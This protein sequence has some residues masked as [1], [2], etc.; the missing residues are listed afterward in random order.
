MRCGYPKRRGRN[1]WRG[2]PSIEIGGF[3]MMRQFIPSSVKYPAK[4]LRNWWFY[5]GREK[6]CPVCEHRL[7]RFMP[8]GSER[9]TRC[10]W[11]DGLPRHRLAILFLDQVLGIGDWPAATP[12]LHIAPERHL[13]RRL[14]KQFGAA[15]VT[16]DLSSRNV[17]VHCD[18]TD[19]PFRDDS[20]ALILCSHVLEHVE[21][22]RK[23]LAECFRI[24]KPGGRAVILVPVDDGR[25][26]TY[27][28]PSIV[29]RADRGAHFGQEDH[30]RVYG[31]D[32]SDRVRA[33]GF[34]LKVHPADDFL[35]PEAI[36]EMDIL[37]GSGDIFEAVKP[38][39]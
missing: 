9:E 2:L 35:A 38:L 14:R 17:D 34:I 11:C 30:V 1:T 25:A 7:S 29:S 24:L 8:A 23:A 3:Q 19:M 22:D 5:R 15:Y 26:E 33:A 4:V 36:A 32:F 21:D 12:V 10:P 18:I 31:R 20:F 37:S 13:T 16:T 28:D 6:V 27:E 39:S